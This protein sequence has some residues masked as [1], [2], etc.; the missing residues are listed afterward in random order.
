MSYYG[1]TIHFIAQNW[2]L[3]SLGL[4]FGPSHGDHTGKDIAGIFF[5][6]LKKAGVEKKIQGITVDNAS[7][8]TVFMEELPELLHVQGIDFDAK[9]QHFNCFPHILNLAVHDILDS[10]E[11]DNIQLVNYADDNDSDDGNELV[12]SDITP[13]QLPPIARLREMCKKIKKSEKFKNKLE[14]H[15]AG[16]LMEHTQIY[17]SA[18]EPDGTRLRIS[19]KREP[20]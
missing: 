18:L 5:E 20:K 13:E 12:V 3:P 14:K 11:V 4:D 15:C 9:D 7:V 2:E 1:I 6:S 8:N 16:S 10:L 17:H 19:S